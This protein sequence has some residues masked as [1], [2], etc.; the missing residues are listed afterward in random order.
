MRTSSD[1]F[2]PDNG[3]H[4]NGAD[5]GNKPLPYR[6]AGVSPIASA[7]FNAELARLQRTLIDGDEKKNRLKLLDYLGLLWRGKWI[8]LACL[9]A[10]GSLAAYYTYSLPFIYESSLQILVNEREQSVPLLTSPSYWTNSDRELK[11]E[12]QILTSRPILEKTAARLMDIRYVDTSTRTAVLPVIAAAETKLAPRF[13]KSTPQEA[14]SLMVD[15]VVA[16]LRKMIIVTPSKDADIIQVTTHAGDPHEAALISNVYADI[17]IADNLEQNSR[18]AKQMKQFVSKQMEIT[19][20][21]LSKQEVDLKEYLEENGILGLDLQSSDLVA[22]KSKLENEAAQTQI[23][24]S[25]LSRKLQE[26]KRQYAEVDSTFPAE[27]ASGSWVY[28]T[29]LQEQIAE[30]TIRKNLMNSKEFKGAST[31]GY[32][33]MMRKEDQELAMLK[34]QLDSVVTKLKDSKV[35]AAL[36]PSRDGDMPTMAVSSLKRQIFEDEIA[37]QALKAQYGAIMAA[38]GEIER[39]IAMVPSQELDVQRLQREKTALD[40]IYKELNEEYNK[41]VLEEQ[42]VTPTA[43]IFEPALPVLKPV[44]PNR[45]ANIAVGIFIGLAIGVGIALLLAYSDTTVHSPDELEKNGFTVLTTIPLIP[46]G[47]LTYDVR[48]GDA[49]AQRLNG[50]AS[51]HLIA[52]IQ[53]KAP[54]AEAYRSLRTAVQFA[55]IEEPARKILVAS[56]VPQEGKSTTSTNLAITLAQSGA[57]T[58]LIDCDLRRPTQNSVFGLPREPGLVNCLIGTKRLEEAIHPSGVPNLDILTSG[59]IPPNPSELIGSRRMREML[60]ELED[61]YDMIIIDSPPV[62]A[63]TDAVILSTLADT[64]ILVV[65]AHKT[66][67]EFLEKAREGLERVNMP[68]LGVVLNDFDV[69]QSYGSASYRYYRYYRYYN[70]YGGLEDEQAG[71]SRKDRRARAALKEFRSESKEIR[72]GS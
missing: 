31:L 1:N 13:L 17:Y 16:S 8:I 9:I 51:S 44:S 42:S 58:L 56:S 22:A 63:V 59:T 64:T 69:S 24:I 38:K 15:Q 7:P 40:K 54:I 3:G 60:T 61:H 50:R 18:K 29:K 10:T 2:N 49:L 32:E 11:K 34:H 53:P 70:Y 33:N 71:K 30:R 52:H 5:N 28:A 41:K 45:T 39:K 21:S 20:D 36:N 66:K 46:S 43:R 14:H 55:G 6:P 37:L 62:G 68:L 47:A 72:N 48:E 57:R 35:T 23:E 19:R 25:T 67:M 4:K 12:L 65:R 27:F 26:A